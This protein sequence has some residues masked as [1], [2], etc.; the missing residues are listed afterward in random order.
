MKQQEVEFNSLYRIT[1]KDNQKHRGVLIGAFTNKV[2]SGSIWAVTTKIDLENDVYSSERV[3]IP[4][5]E[6]ANFKKIKK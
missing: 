4:M 1:P 5:E 3:F 2:F 6:I